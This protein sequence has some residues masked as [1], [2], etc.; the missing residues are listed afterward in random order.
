[1]AGSA[2]PG[3]LDVFVRGTDNAVWTKHA[4]NGAWGPWTSMGWVVS[5]P[6]AAVANGGGL[7][8]FARGVDNSLW[9]VKV[10]NGAIGWPASVGGILK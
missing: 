8:L 7:D 1:M 10:M 6:V 4:A 5:S 3:S 9:A 2:A